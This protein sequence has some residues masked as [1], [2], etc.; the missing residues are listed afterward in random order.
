MNTL[1]LT[2]QLLETRTS[3]ERGENAQVRVRLFILIGPAKCDCPGVRTHQEPGRTARKDWNGA[4]CAQK[5]KA[6]A[7]PAFMGR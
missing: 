5:N 2:T 3:P 1:F 6:N 4:L 7:R